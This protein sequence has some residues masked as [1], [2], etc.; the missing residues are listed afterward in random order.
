M[1]QILEVILQNGINYPALKNYPCNKLFLTPAG[2]ETY[3]KRVRRV[4]ERRLNQKELTVLFV[5]R[6]PMQKP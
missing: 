2:V 6:E 5:K 3:R 1:I 4:F